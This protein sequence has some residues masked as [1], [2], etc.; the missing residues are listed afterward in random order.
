MKLSSSD[1]ERVNNAIDEILMRN[2]DGRL[3]PL[4]Y[5]NYSDEQLERN[6]HLMMRNFERR[7][8][9]KVVMNGSGEH[10]EEELPDVD[11]VMC[12]QCGEYSVH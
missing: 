9:S 5:L 11:G 3:L 6:D 4:Q 8:F 1:D 12:S 7:S 10:H 2:G